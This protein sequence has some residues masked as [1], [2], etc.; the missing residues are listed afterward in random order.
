MRRF[1][2]SS[3]A[4]L[5]LL[6]ATAST[7]LMATVTVNDVCGGDNGTLSVGYTYNDQTLGVQSLIVNNNSGGSAS[8]IAQ[9]LDDQGN[10]LGTFTNGINANQPQIVQNIN[11]LNLTMVLRTGPRGTSLQ[12]PG[13]LT[14]TITPGR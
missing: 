5:L 8:I 13:F 2:L 1:V 6:G 11:S 14:C 3:V 10:V 7:A 4:A 12:F 9:I